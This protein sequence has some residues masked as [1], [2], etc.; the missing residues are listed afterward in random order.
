MYT[1]VADR[2]IDFGPDFEL[3]DQG[4]LWYLSKEPRKQDAVLHPRGWATPQRRILKSDAIRKQMTDIGFK[5]LKSKYLYEEN[6]SGP[7][8]LFAVYSK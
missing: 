4:I 7:L 8:R 1:I 5:E 6:E 2:S 3:D